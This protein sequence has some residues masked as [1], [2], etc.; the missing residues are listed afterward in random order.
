M[1][2]INL[3]KCPLAP[4]ATPSGGCSGTPYGDTLITANAD[5]TSE[6]DFGSPA[7]DYPWEVI[8]DTDLVHM[9]H[10]A[11]GPCFSGCESP[12]VNIKVGG[13][14]RTNKFPVDH[15]KN[16]VF[17]MFYDGE[18]GA[19]ITAD[20]LAYDSG[21]NVIGIDNFTNPM[22]TNLY[23]GVVSG[24]RTWSV[25]QAQFEGS[26]NTVNY[27]NWS[28]NFTT[29]TAVGHEFLYIG[30]LKPETVEMQIEITGGDFMLKGFRFESSDE[31]I[32]SMEGYRNCLR[33]ADTHIIL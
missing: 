24:D 4:G 30:K 14:F 22:T 25:M 32:I 33:K 31:H 5:F 20:F 2:D 6:T 8:G 17:S 13:T 11:R 1:P 12:T 3:Y 27:L 15:N 19:G 7:A 28:G 18:F 23:T 9:G 16:Y 10:S 29:D 21:G 26:G